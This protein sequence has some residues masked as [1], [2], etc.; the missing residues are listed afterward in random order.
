MSFVERMKS[1]SP[2]ILT[3]RNA[4]NVKPSFTSKK[5]HILNSPQRGA[6]RDIQKT[7]AKETTS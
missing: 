4:S 3:R 2:S 1:F 7:A 5:S 6:L